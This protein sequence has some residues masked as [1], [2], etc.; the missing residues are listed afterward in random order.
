MVHPNFV[1]PHFCRMSQHLSLRRHVVQF[2]T[3]LRH[4]LIVIVCINNVIF[5][6]G[7]YG[8]DSALEKICR[9]V[10]AVDNKKTTHDGS[11]IQPHAVILSSL[12]G[13]A[14]CNVMGVVTR[15]SRC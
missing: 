7:S 8:P 2:E 9:A 3:T 4:L 11:N 6:G 5:V 14:D 1:P 10:G 15:V 13:A 12:V